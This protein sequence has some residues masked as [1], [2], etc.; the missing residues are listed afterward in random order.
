MK[1]PAATYRLQFNLEF[2]FQKAREILSYLYELGISDIYASPVFKAKAGSPHGYDVVELN[3]LNPDLG[4]TDDFNELIYHMKV[5]EMGW[6]QDIVPNHMAFDGENQM[7]MDVLENGRH[8][9][10]L[11]FFDIEW[12]HFYESLRERVLAPFLG[13]HYSECLDA[14][15]I[16]LQYDSNGFS[17]NYYMLK[18]MYQTIQQQS[19]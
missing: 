11:D 19:H 9:E 4:S 8:S 2:G 14:G 18:L 13:R 17:I 3:Q 10:Y 7:L 16:V 5:L 1:I 15:E 12:G 6:L